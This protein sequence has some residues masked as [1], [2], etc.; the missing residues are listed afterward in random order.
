MTTATTTT[1]LTGLNDTL[2]QLS[3]EFTITG[4]DAGVWTITMPDT[5]SQVDLD[6]AIVTEIGILTAIANMVIL[7]AQAK[8]AQTGNNNFLAIPT[9]TQAQSLAQIKALTRQSTALIKM[10]IGD[11]DST[12]GTLSA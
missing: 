3:P 11:L 1:E 10:V 8:A 7:S 12:T 6:A 2:N 9:P 5:V 4:P